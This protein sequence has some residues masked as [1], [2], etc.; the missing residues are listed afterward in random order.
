MNFET[1]DI[2]YSQLDVLNKNLSGTSR[3]LVF[4]LFNKINFDKLN[5]SV[6][7][8]TQQN[9]LFSFS[10]M[11]IDNR[12]QFILNSQSSETLNLFEVDNDLQKANEIM[13]KLCEKKYQIDGSIV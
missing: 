9:V 5:E 12:P 8:L 3:C 13:K 1:F 7:I 11:I 4:K 6:K 2:S 10:A